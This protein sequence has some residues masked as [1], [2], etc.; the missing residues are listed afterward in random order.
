MLVSLLTP[1]INPKDWLIKALDSIKSTC[2]D[3]SEIE[4]LLRVDDN[5]ASR[6]ADLPEL[7]ARYGVKAIIGPRGAGYGNMGGIIDE[8][9]AI[10]TGKWC[11]LFDDD[12]W[13]EGNTWQQQLREIPCD[14]VNGVGVFCEFYKLDPSIYDNKDGISP[15]GFIVPTAWAKRWTPSSTPIDACWFGGMKQTGA[16]VKLLK[17]M[18]FG[19]NGRAR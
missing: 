10:A 11:W 17:G 15:Q 3:Y 2:C 14:E 19:H 9:L 13:L 6:I 8:L 18:T 12:A 4:I 7:E 16:P 5:N 1:T